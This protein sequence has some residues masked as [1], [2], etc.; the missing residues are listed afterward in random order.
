MRT[1]RHLPAFALLLWGLLPAAGCRAQ[2][3]DAAVQ[4]AG[5]VSPLPED[6]RDGATVRGYDA[7]GNLVTLREGANGLICLA[8]DPNRE[9]FHAACYHASLE[10]YMARGR[11]LRAQGITGVESFE[12]RH[13]EAEEGKLKMPEA[14]ATVYNLSGDA[15][16]PATGTVTAPRRL[17]AVYIPYATPETTG[18]PDRP[19]GPGAPWI[20]RPGTPSAHIMISPPSN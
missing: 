8:D 3:P 18:L 7:D 6:L 1:T 17:Y 4:I 11:E 10:P 12:V 16:D 5:A 14:P 13:R 20:M 15:F 19:P 2:V 9:G